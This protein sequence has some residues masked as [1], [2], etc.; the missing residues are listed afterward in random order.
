MDDV[1]QLIIKNLVGKSNNSTKAN[2]DIEMKVKN[3][4]VYKTVSSLL[5]D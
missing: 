4:S 1:S 3:T 5:N 2:E